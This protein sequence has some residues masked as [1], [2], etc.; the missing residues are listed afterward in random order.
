VRDIA[1]SGGRI[2]AIGDLSAAAA[3][4]TIDAKGLHVLPGVLDHVNAG[5]PSLE[6]FVDLTSA[7]AGRQGCTFRSGY[8]PSPL[9]G[10]DAWRSIMAWVIS[11]ELG[12]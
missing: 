10:F 8:P 3:A 1:A 5:R 2:A 4:E 6:R 11:P 7:A 9:C 12:Q